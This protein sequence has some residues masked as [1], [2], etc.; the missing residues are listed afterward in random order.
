MTQR[1][2]NSLY[3]RYL[4]QQLHGWTAPSAPSAL[5]S[6]V[7]FVLFLPGEELLQFFI[8]EYEQRDQ[9]TGA[10]PLLI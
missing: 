2:S 10:R 3:R 9:T 6:Q 7:V 5:P 4:Q 1:C 8:N